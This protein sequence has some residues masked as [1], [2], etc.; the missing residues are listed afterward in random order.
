MTSQNELREAVNRELDQ[1]GQVVEEF[2]GIDPHPIAEMI[3]AELGLPRD[4]VEVAVRDE[5]ARRG[6]S[7]PPIRVSEGDE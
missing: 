6:I 1:L 3:S 7:V 4:M 5:A 2:G